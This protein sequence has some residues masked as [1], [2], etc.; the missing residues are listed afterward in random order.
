MTAGGV[1]TV[2]AGVVAAVSAGVSFLSLVVLSDLDGLLDVVE[3]DADDP[4]LG[5]AVHGGGSAVVRRDVSVSVAV[6]A[7]AGPLVL[8]LLGQ[9][10]VLDFVEEMRV[11]VVSL[12]FGMAD[13]HGRVMA[14][15]AKA[16]QR[17]G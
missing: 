10:D 9:E 6:T 12:A 7:G 11:Y 8:D 5:H 4:L 2:T 15:A 14:A 17:D 13:G 16:A 3:L 1:A